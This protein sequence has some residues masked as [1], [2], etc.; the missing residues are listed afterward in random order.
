M[1]SIRKGKQE[2][3]EP[4]WHI[5]TRAIRE[6]CRSHY[7]ENELAMWADVLEPE[8]YRKS[9]ADGTLLVAEEEGVLIGFGNLNKATS[10]IEAMYVDP[11]HIGRGV[12]IEILQ[13]LEGLAAEL[14]LTSLHLSA[15]LNAVGFYEK[16]GYE[17]RRQKRYLL[18]YER[19]VCVNMVKKLNQRNSPRSKG[20]QKRAG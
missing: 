1:I 2:D 18:P 20:S 5:H 11:D 6:V 7:A 15:S 8:R 12:G 3:K 10:E 16:A 14:S 9:I 4:I 13:A 19:V 17:S